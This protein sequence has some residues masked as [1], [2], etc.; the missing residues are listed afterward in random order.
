MDAVDDPYKYLAHTLVVTCSDKQI[1][2]L[3]HDSKVVKRF[4]AN[5]INETEFIGDFIDC[6][7][8]DVIKQGKSRCIHTALKGTTDFFYKNLDVPRLRK[9]MLVYCAMYGK[10]T[11]YLV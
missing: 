6:I 8:V 3:L 7:M 4:I 5:E 9:E 10:P 11:E 1:V 2:D